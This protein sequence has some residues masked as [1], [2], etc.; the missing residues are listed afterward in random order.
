MSS[1]LS[2]LI[3]SSLDITIIDRH[4]HLSTCFTLEHEISSLHVPSRPHKSSLQ[5]KGL[6]APWK[7]QSEVIYMLGDGLN[8][9]THIYSSTCLRVIRTVVRVG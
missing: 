3:Y 2:F 4:F 8:I 9:Y 1:L 7:F 5:S 6:M